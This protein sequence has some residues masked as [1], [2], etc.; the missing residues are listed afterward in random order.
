M[1]TLTRKCMFNGWKTETTEHLEDCKDSDGKP[2]ERVIEFITLKK[3]YSGVST[4]ASVY[5]LHPDGCKT[6]MAFEDYSQTVQ[7]FLKKRAT[8][9]G[10]MDCHTEASVKFAEHIAAAKA[11]YNIK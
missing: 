6:F 11:Q 3:R 7:I 9:K 1:K 2:V 4:H 5:L 10:I 8:Q